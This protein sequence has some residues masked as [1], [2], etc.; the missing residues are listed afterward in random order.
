MIVA[1]LGLAAVGFGTRYVIRAMPTLGK[2]MAEA[3]T[4]IPRLD[5]KVCLCI[6]GI[7]IFN[8]LKVI[9]SH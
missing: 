7:Y 6:I 3:A 4:S 9:T 5:G 2:K 1:G 8:P